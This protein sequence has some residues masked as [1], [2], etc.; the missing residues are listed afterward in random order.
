MAFAKFKENQFRI[1]GDIA[2]NHAIL[3]NLMA[4]ILYYNN[5]S[6]SLGFRAIDESRTIPAIRLTYIACFSPISQSILNRF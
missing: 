2:E 6:L 5:T 1:A 4:S 3:V